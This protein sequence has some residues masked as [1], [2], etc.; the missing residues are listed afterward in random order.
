LADKVTEWLLEID[1]PSVRYLTLTS[2]LDK[3]DDDKKVTEA[4]KAIMAYGVVPEILALQNEDGSWGLPEMFYRNKYAGTVWTLMVLAEMGADKDDPRIKKTCEFILKHA[5]E[6]ESGGFSCCESVKTGAGLPSGVVP[7][8]TGNMVYTLIKLGWLSDERLTKAIDWIVKY[9]RTDDGV[10]NAPSGA[11]YEKYAMC[12]GKHSCHMGVAKALKALAAI[13][14]E[15]R[16]EAVNNKIDEMAEYFLTHHIYKKS[17]NLSEISRPGWLKFGFPLMYQTDI[18]E[19][20]EMFVFL[21]IK[22][23]RLIDAV[24]IIKSKQLPDGTWKLENSNNGKM[25]IRIENKGKPSKW[26]TLKALNVLKEY[27]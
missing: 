8:L 19:L 16:S 14:P 12:W 5:Q 25:I 15:N 3:P 27:Q 18:L 2:L 20:L 13:P 10:E 6:P 22:D 23:E 11:P 21:G 7:C 4:K 1:N 26:I 9:Q 17:H 24:E